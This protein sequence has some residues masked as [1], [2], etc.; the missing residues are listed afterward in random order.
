MI[1]ARELQQLLEGI[2]F[3]DQTTHPEIAETAKELKKNIADLNKTLVKLS[4]LTPDYFKILKEI[5]ERQEDFDF[6][7]KVKNRE[8]TAIT[9]LNDLSECIKQVFKELDSSEKAQTLKEELE[10]TANKLIDLVDG[11][12]K[13]HV[14]KRRIALDR[15]SNELDSF[16]DPVGKPEK[17]FEGTGVNKATGDR[18][19][20]LEVMLKQYLEYTG[21]KNGR[22][23]IMYIDFEPY[24]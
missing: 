20:E 10:V 23:G 22:D 19:T 7:M 12:E 11:Y 18:F 5:K 8:I 14:S 2:E 9:L 24:Y 1:N 15:L 17:K 16:N 3:I 4:N 21:G 6:Y 13:K